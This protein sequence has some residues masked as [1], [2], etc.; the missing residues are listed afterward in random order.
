MI[1]KYIIDSNCFITPHRS[2]CPTDVGVSFWNKVRS[3]YE[4]GAICSLDKVK[5]ELYGNSDD[6]KIW[7]T[8]NLKEDFFLPFENEASVQRLS[9]IMRWASASTFYTSKA[10]EKFLRMDKADI[11]LA[12][13]ASVNPQQWTVV[14]METSAPNSPGEIKLPDVCNQ[15]NVKCIQ[16][17]SMFR[18]L[19]EV[20]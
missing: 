18:E 3:L 8:G 4:T 20:Y 9:E 19:G 5:D 13:F 7:M 1:M 17:Q 10:K 11:Y 15:Y 14:S 12:S 6:L 16:L 2:F